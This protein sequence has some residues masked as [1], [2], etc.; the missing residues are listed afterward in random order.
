MHFKDHNK[1]CVFSAVV[2]P[3]L[4]SPW[5]CIS[6]NVSPSRQPHKNL[7]GILWR[8]SSWLDQHRSLTHW[9]SWC[10]KRSLRNTWA[11]QEEDRSS[12]VAGSRMCAIVKSHLSNSIC[13]TAVVKGRKRK[14]KKNCWLRINHQHLPYLWYH[15]NETFL[16]L[17][18]LT[19]INWFMLSEQWP[20][21]K[22]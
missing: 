7:S 9:K 5:G 20:H 13:R 15:W 22:N 2:S 10:K 21:H 4:S 11:E 16:C 3:W 1:K 8:V 17:V 18:Y 6:A 19:L 14:K 12:E